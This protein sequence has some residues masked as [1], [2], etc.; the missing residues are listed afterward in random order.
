MNAGHIAHTQWRFL[1]AGGA[2]ATHTH[3]N[4]AHDWITDQMYTHTH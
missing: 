4:P 3:A 1:V 2:A